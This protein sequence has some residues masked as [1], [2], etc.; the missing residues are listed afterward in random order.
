MR[1]WTAQYP[2]ADRSWYQTNN[3]IIIVTVKD[4]REFEK[5]LKKAADKGI[6]HVAFVEPDIGYQKTA[7]A[8][9]PSTETA[10]LM[11]HCQLLG[12]VSQ[13]N[14]EP[15]TL[16]DWKLLMKKHMQGSH[17]LSLWDHGN[18]CADVFKSLMTKETSEVFPI[19]WLDTAVDSFIAEY[20]SF[21]EN[22][23]IYQDILTT[24]RFHDIGKV[25]AKVVDEDGRIHFPDHP[26]HSKA[27][28]RKLDSREHI[29]RW[30]GNGM[31]LLSKTKAEC[32]VLEDLPILRLMA[33]SELIANV[34]DGIF[35]S[36][37]FDSISVKIKL[38]KL[39]RNG[40]VK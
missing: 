23:P 8:F 29:A 35:G 18:H 28:W 10:Y 15:L 26:D 12:G 7:A 36:M 30:L 27:I 1:E 22:V 40:T 4:I 3:S 11:R 24:L 37:D 31:H 5:M 32:E 6:G 14:D 2:E 9:C 16:L 21:S 33:A 34:R 38:K 19:P 39:V 17:D 13:T 25:T 20:G